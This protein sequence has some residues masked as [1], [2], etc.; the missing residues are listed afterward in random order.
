VAAGRIKPGDPDTISSLEALRAPSIL[1]DNADHLMPGDD[2]ELDIRKL[3]LYGVKV[4]MADP[5]DLNT[6]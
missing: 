4:C 6:D 1:F 2:R 3:P 5:A